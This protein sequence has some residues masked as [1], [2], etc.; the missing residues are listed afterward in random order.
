[1]I[2]IVVYF[3]KK[4]SVN[5]QENENLQVAT[6]DISILQQKL[7][8]LE[9][10]LAFHNKLIEK[11]HLTNEKNNDMLLQNENINNYLNDKVVDVKNENKVLK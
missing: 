6:L 9:N 3:F 11:F 8:E 5:P 4:I 7:I 10:T 1:M 2:E